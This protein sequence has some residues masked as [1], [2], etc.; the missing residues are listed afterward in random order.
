MTIQQAKTNLLQNLSTIYDEREAESMTRII[1]EDINFLKHRQAKEILNGGHL[2]L[3][4][5]IEARLLAHEPLQYVL[6]E[7][8]FYGLKFKVNPHVLIP[9]PETEELVQWIKNDITD[10]TPTGEGKQLLDIGTGSGC[11]ALTLQSK[12]P[13]LELSA[14]DVS[15]LALSV[16]SENA[17]RLGLKV[18][19]ICTD[20]L[21][22]KSTAS[23]P[24]YDYIVS[25]PP[26]IPIK[27]KTDMH[28]NV[29]DH[30]PHLALFVEDTDPLLFYRH[31]A[32]FAQTHLNTGGALYFEIHEKYAK[33]IQQLLMNYHFKNII[34]KKDIYEKNRMIRAAL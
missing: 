23:L 17:K 29:L 27:D 8:D 33:D 30:E 1:F 6:G 5:K 20:I 2:A 31:I 26:Y 16:V 13:D 10:I 22:P 34:T 7:A 32:L 15:E 21:D 4:S 19:L 14:L 11:I 18:K 25:N 3:L 24:V 28:K 12:L 9:R